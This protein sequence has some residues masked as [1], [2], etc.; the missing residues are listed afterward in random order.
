MTILK[1]LFQNRAS[2][3]AIQMTSKHSSKLI[4]L[5]TQR[6]YDFY[7]RYLLFGTNFYTL[8]NERKKKKEKKNKY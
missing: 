8:L 6:L 7:S 3:M 5:E 4:C 1:W 2:E